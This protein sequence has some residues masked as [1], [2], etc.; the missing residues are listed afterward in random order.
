M[1]SHVI[2]RFMTLSNYELSVFCP[3]QHLKPVLFFFFF[4]SFFLFFRAAPEAF[5]SSQTRGRIGAVAAS[6][7]HSRSNTRSKQH[8]PPS[9]QLMATHW[10]RP[11]IE[12]VSSWTLV[13]FYTAEPQW[14]PL[15]CSFS[16]LV[17]KIPNH[18]SF[19]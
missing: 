11:E 10:V 8:L 14:E 16:L 9:L 3:W 12:P 6:Q 19:V 2:L 7:C 4:F 5:G 18:A 17:W 15:C 1:E 13:G